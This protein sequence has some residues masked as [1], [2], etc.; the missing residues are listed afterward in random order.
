MCTVDSNYRVAATLLP[1]SMICFRY[2]S[3]IALHEGDDDD[4]DECLKTLAFTYAFKGTCY[5]SHSGG[6]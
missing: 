3:V 1:R 4:D 6:T 2:I 5:S